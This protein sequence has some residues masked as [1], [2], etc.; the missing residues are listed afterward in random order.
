[1]ERFT[2]LKN[3]QEAEIVVKKS[4]FIGIAFPCD[5]VDVFEKEVERIQ[6]KYPGARHYCYA[7]RFLEN[8]INER[9]QDDKEPSG[10]AGLPILE[11]LRHHDVLQCAVV[12]VRY[13][14]GT[15]LGTGG[16]SRAYSD[17]ARD[18]LA[19]SIFITQVKAVECEIRADYHFSGK[20]DYYLNTENI[21]VVDT[22]YA[23]QV[24]Y[25]VVVE[26]EQYDQVEND[27]KNIAAN[28]IQFVYMRDVSGYYEGK[29]FIEVQ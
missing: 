28:N 10:T 6:R 4:R 27:L 9:Y 17:A 29:D 15:L 26:K 22:Q 16:L 25:T 18:A 11:V 14:G 20:I 13:F 8:I 21:P 2:T 24:T 19:A 7:Y 12:V 3:Q 23:D 5:S 1:M